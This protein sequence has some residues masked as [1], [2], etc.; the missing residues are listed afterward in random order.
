MTMMPKPHTSR[1]GAAAVIGGDGWAGVGGAGI[2]PVAQLSYRERAQRLCR[3]GSAVTWIEAQAGFRGRHRSPRPSI[4][5][6]WR[7]RISGTWRVKG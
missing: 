5:L 7:Q 2:N 3:E 4:R 1:R 6:S